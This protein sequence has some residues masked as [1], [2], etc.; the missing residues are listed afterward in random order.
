MRHR[1]ISANFSLLFILAIAIFSAGRAYAQASGATLSGTVTDPSGAAIAGAKVSIAN[2]ATGENRDVNTN[3][4]GL[5]SAPNLLPGV[6]DVTASASGFSTAKQSDVTLTVGAS[7]TLN[8]PLKVGEASQTIEVTAAAPLVQLGSSALSSD[9]NTTTVTELP[10]NG[11]DWASLATLTPGVN[12]IE[13]QLPFTSGALRGNRGFGSQLTISGGRPTQNNYQLDG[14]SINDYSGTGPGSVI[15]VQLGVDAIAE[16]SVLSGNYSAEYGKTSG[17]VI[18]AVS[19]SG[20]N[21]FHGDIYEF[22]RNTALDANDFFSNSSHLPTAVFRRNQFGAAVG[23][24]IR[25]DRTFFFF[26]YE[27]IRQTQGATA[28]NPVPS[29]AARAGNLVSGHINVDPAVQKYLALYPHANGAV[30]G[31]TGSFTFQNPQIVKEN[32]YT[33]RVDHKISDKDSLFATYTFDKAPFT[34]DD[35]YGNISV[36]T[37]TDRHIAALEESHIFG[38]SLLNTARLGF[39]RNGVIN[40]QSVSALNPAA[41]DASLGAFPGGFNPQTNIS[42]VARLQAGVGGGYSLFGWN[43]YQFHDDAFLTRG[44]HSLKFGFAMER[45]QFNFFQDYNPYGI[46]RFS[47]LKNFLLNQPKSLEGGMPGSLSPRG[48]RQTIFAGYTQDDWHVRH[49][50]TVNVGLRYEMATVINEVQGKLTN[51]ATFSS[52]LPYCGTTAPNPVTLLFGKQGCTPGAQPLYSNPSTLNFEPR[53][54]FAWDPRGNGKTAVR[55]GYA[56]FDVLLLP[57]YFYT[58][59]SIETPFFLDGI[60]ASKPGKPLAGIGVLAGTP[61]SAFSTIGVNGLNGAY[62]EPNPKRNYVQQWNINVQQQITPNLTA[63]V[64]YI[65]SHGVHMLIRGDDGNMVLPTPVSAGGGFLW[66]AQASGNNPA[67]PDLRIN[68][69]FGG[70]RF[71]SWGTDASYEAVTFSVQKRMSH[72]F[73]LGGSYT[74]SKA[75]DSSSATIAGDAFS[76]SITS[77]FWFAPQISHAPSDFNIPHSVVINGIWQVPGPRAG[78]AHAVLGGWEM[79]SIFKMN[80]GIPTTPLINSDPLGVQNAGSDE[81]G[82]PS[83]VPGCNPVNTNFRSSPNLGYI[84]TKCYT[85]PQ[86]TPAIAAQCAP[87]PGFPGTCE[88]LL[89]NAGRNSI[90]G[91]SLINLDFALYKNMAVKKISENFNVQ[92]RAEFF[93]VLNHASFLPPLDFQGGNTAQLFNQNG[94]PLGGSAGSLTTL[95]NLP[96]IIQFA[97]KVI[98]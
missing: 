48:L 84:N 22:L 29:D 13:T 90:V 17:G 54:G 30:N 37:Q 62:M 55:G 67:A 71:L 3:A 44:T 32:Y 75:M 94:T 57:G 88:N 82:I 69:N 68:P 26:D 52:P 27:G 60:V 83:I 33:T 61:G 24:P 97:L 51:I 72:G 80:N 65:G 31:D 36:L 53:L 93:N 50:L 7:Q 1:A 46:W 38:P 5:Y 28:T 34:Q 8:M 2:K 95:A 11:R 63:T 41:A 89:G 64:G 43:S 87:F 58:Q 85:L 14:N 9:I 70:I 86:A 35:I 25:K 91:P 21:A 19:K 12:G 96:R 78:V 49:N 45:E 47:S 56:I 4:A 23:G 77:W 6:Y 42:G 59:E 16:F 76:N 73:Q 40:S 18:N 39:N 92:F 81:F 79:G 66:P 98:F 15:G 20:T 10:L 74:Y